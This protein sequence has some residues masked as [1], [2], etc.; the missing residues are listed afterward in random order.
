MRWLPSWWGLGTRF[1]VL[2]LALLLL[3]QAAGFATF[4]AGIAANARAQVADELGTGERALQR[5]LAQ[6]ATRLA[7]AA[8][9]LAADWGFR[10]AV[11]S[12]D[13]E[14]IRSA[15]DNHGGRIDASVSALLDVDFR[16]RATTAA[17]GDAL[18]AT[19]AQ[20]ATTVRDPRGGSAPSPAVVAL[21]DGVPTQ[22]VLAPLRT[23]LPVG[24]VLT[25]FA[26]DRRLGD[27][28]R[29]VSEVELALLVRDR[30][31]APWRSAVTRLD[32]QVDAALRGQAASRRGAATAVL[33]STEYGWRSVALAA[34]GGEVQA[35]LLR[36]VDD[37]VRPYRQLQWLLAAITLAGV[38]AFAA[39]GILAARRITQPVRQLVA[40][41]QRL[42]RGDL[43]TPVDGLQ[44]RDEIGNL[45]R[46]FDGMRQDIASQQAALERLAYWDP[47][48]DLP[49]RARFGDALRAAIAAADPARD[50][51][52]VLMLDLD[53]FKHVND[54][55]GYAFGDRLLQAVAQRLAQQ[56]QRPG[57]LLARLSGDEFALL[58]PG[59]GP[60]QA[61][62]IAQ[63]IVVAFEA[64]L[65]LDEQTV[66]L[67]AGVGA[68]CWPLHGGDAQTL[69]SR[70]EVAMF[71]AKGRSAG[72]LLY[73]AAH[74]VG[75]AQT[76]SLLTELKRAVDGGELRLYLQPKLAL[77]D[78]RL[79]GAEAL[80]RW[81]HPERGL[82]PPAQFIPFAEQTGF[83]RHLTLWMFEQ[84]ARHWQVLSEAAGHP[85]RLAVNLSTRDLLDQDLPD[86]LAGLLA[87]HGAPAGAFCLEITESAIMDDP[88]RAEA[89]LQRLAARG[90]KLSID[91]FGTGYSSLAYLKRLPVSELKIDKSFVMG[92][93]R[94]AGDAKIVRSTVDLA[95]NLGLSVVAEGVE[96]AE[97]WNALHR[98]DC[99]EAQGFHMSRPLPA[100]QF[101][102]WTLRW[103]EHAASG[104]AG[105]EGV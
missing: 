12:D 85:L 96:S 75:S 93:A 24:W 20:I 14:T 102:A 25:G 70:A 27:D 53:R 22:F 13:L 62:T 63:R 36:S 42:G 29:A 33:G 65:T 66:D 68:A 80:V 37:V 67:S 54:V 47:L 35:V 15:L 50:R 99:D 39:G 103:R 18:A 1:V 81:Q 49:N 5:L 52:A 43:V 55:L 87:R 61:L 16:V 73:D 58:L 26:L 69:L 6:G 56:V 104:W 71:A 41:A 57:D 100:D 4:R 78:G 30:P 28:L 60:Q 23:P 2:F 76:L 86:K 19:I 94:D 9:L 32:P 98:L 64:S 92:M 79:I 74:D 59:C 8:R 82:V 48:T 91:D 34:D 7:D 38:A 90:F 83:I 89:T 44:G 51:L 105:L 31:G 88:Q 95:H 72:P 10:E 11:N 46:A 45:A 21:W 97:I 17:N 101:V 84:A 77:A 3:I 40:A